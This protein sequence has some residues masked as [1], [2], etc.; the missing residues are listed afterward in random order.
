LSSDGY[1]AH[2]RGERELAVRLLELASQLSPFDRELSRRR[3]EAVRG[4]VSGTADEIA[5]L[6]Q[7]LKSL[8]D[9]F[10]AHQQLDFALAKQRKFDRVIEMWTEYLGRHSQDGA[11]Y[12]ERSGAYHNS[13][14]MPEA[15]TDL[16]K[17]CELGVNQA[18]AYQKRL[19]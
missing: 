10:S 3:E 15:M 11:A 8:P 6:E 17:A 2:Q 14:R 19:K 7:Q 9:D 18:C 5:R 1:A 12:F 4:N 16:A 13:G